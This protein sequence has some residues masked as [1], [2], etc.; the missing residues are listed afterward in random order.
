M[1]HVEHA[2]DLRTQMTM[3]SCSPLVPARVAQELCSNLV[4]EA[5]AEGGASC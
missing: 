2:I 3:R 4:Y 1:T 5:F